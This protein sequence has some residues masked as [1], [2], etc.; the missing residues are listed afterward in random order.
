[1]RLRLSKSQARHLDLLRDAV[2]PFGTAGASRAWVIG[3]GSIRVSDILLLRSAI[4]EH[5][6]DPMMQ[7][8][9]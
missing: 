1:M 2:S 5:P 6:L 3:T 8:R 4:L 7:E 9:S